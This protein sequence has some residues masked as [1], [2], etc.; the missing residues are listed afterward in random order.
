V[1]GLGTIVKAETFL[2]NDLDVN[3]AQKWATKLTAA[4]ILTTRLTNEDV[5]SSLPCAYLVLEGDLTLPKEYQEGMVAAQVAKSEVPFTM[6][7]S[8]AGHSPHLS[9]T[10][11]MVDVIQ[12]FAH[13]AAT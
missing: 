10:T 3:E 8:P 2:F 1:E 12:K 4:P 9:W 7:S 13:T 11:G 6:Y 5:Y